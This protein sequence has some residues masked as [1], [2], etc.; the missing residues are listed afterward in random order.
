MNKLITTTALALMIA[1][2]AAYA[3]TNTEGDAEINDEN[4]DLETRDLN[5]ND[6]AYDDLTFDNGDDEFLFFRGADDRRY[7]IR[8]SDTMMDDTEMTGDAEINDENRDL[9]TRD[10]Q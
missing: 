6:S 9:E 4:R 1:A 2:P 7:R 3:Q 8:R 5:A 10:G